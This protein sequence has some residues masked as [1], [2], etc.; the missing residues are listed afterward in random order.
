VNGHLQRRPAPV[1][2]DGLP[3]DAPRGR[4][5]ELLLAAEML[6]SFRAYAQTHT[7][8][9]ARLAG[10]IVNDVL[11]VR[12]E[13]IPASGIVS[14]EHHVAVGILEVDNLGSHPMTVT[15]GKDSSG[16]APTS[17]RGVRI[18]PAGA[19]RNVPLDARSYSIYGTVGDTVCFVAYSA[20]PGGNGGLGAVDGGSP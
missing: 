6:A 1:G 9:M 4:R 14:G 5:A 19:W 18:I 11:S 2:G 12:T 15:S 13:V 17:G 20:G 3:P 7:A 10:N 16:S 8:F